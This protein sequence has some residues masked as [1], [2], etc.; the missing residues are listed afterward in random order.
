[1]HS[2]CLCNEEISLRNRVLQA[3]PQPDR[4]LVRDAQ[5]VAHRISGWLGR[6][7]PADAE[8][9]ESYTG[10]KRTMYANAYWDLTMTPLNRSDRFLKSF[11]KGEKVSDVSRDPRM[12]QA[13][14]PRYNIC[15]GNYLKPIEHKLYNI[16]GTRQL[17]KLL[18][19]SRL[20]AKGLNHTQRAALL[21][22]KLK[23]GWTCISLDASRFDA[24]VSRELLQV[25]HAVYQGCYPGDS[26]LQR[27]CSWQLV[28]HGW[29]S[30]GIRYKCPGG[31]MSGDMNTALGN[32]LLI[33]IM[34]ATIMR[35]LS[36]KPRDWDMLCDGDDTLLFLPPHRVALLNQV[37]DLFNKFGMEM[38]LDNITKDYHQILFCQ[39]KPIITST[40]YRMVQN[41]DKITSISVCSSKHFLH[42]QTIDGFLTVL[43]KCYLSIYHGV[44]ILQAMAECYIRNGRGKLPRTIEMSGILYR[45][46]REVESATFHDGTSPIT[47]EARL[48]FEEAW[49]YS[50]TEQRTIE[51]FYATL[52]L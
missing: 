30:N 24:H 52:V 20:I 16:K 43:G 29:T 48:S 44:P 42:P 13:R 28:N 50:P 4:S 38:K 14:N 9:V 8:W 26:T 31:R 10:R 39:C 25:E 12:I 47:E 41:P 22:T 7:A 36:C 23:E 18:P 49:G 46:K 34:L 3:V 2:N 35:R 33:V 15:L 1:M 11:I 17:T 40:G 45:A 51:N 21:K 5:K 19:R 6:H 27:L 32:C 37:L